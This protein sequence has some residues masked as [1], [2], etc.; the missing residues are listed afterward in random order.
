MLPLCD[1][2][3]RWLVRLKAASPQRGVRKTRVRRGAGGRWPTAQAGP[4]SAGSL[5]WL[6]RLTC[7]L[8]NLGVGENH[9]VP[10]A[11]VL[12]RIKGPEIIIRVH[13]DNQC[14][15][16]WLVMLEHFANPQAVLTMEAPTHVIHKVSRTR[17]QLLPD[18]PGHAGVP[19]DDRIQH[20]R[21][22]CFETDVR[23][24]LA[25]R[26]TLGSRHPIAPAL[27]VLGVVLR[28]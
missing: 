5:G 1:E 4:P 14:L 8:A 20:V 18:A 12:I 23:A 25:V 13:G 16:A 27:V 11:L 28:W 9:E 21:V 15:A 26:S 22:L 2:E 17:I 7:T 10:F 3:T 24:P 19:E 6:R